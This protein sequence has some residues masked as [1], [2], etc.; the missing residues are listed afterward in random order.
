MYDTGTFS[1]RGTI[2]GMPIPSR[3]RVVAVIA[4]CVAGMLAS[5]AKDPSP[6]PES[7]TSAPTSNGSSEPGLERFYSQTLSW[8]SCRDFESGDSPLRGSVECAYLEVPVDY[9][10]PDGETAQIAMSRVETN[11]DKVGSLLFNPGGPGQPGLWMPGNFARSPLAESFDLVGFD[12]RGVGASTPEVRCLTDAETDAERLDLDIDMSPEGIAQTEKEEK[13]FIDKCVDRVG[14]DVLEH[15]GTREVVRDMDVMR[16]VL[17][18]EKL[19]Y[20]GF[21]YGTRIGAAY[22]EEFP[23]KVRALVLDGAVDASQDPNEELVEQYE[24]FQKAF[25]EF[26]ADCATKSDCPLGTDPRQAVPAFRALVEPLV[27]TPAPAGGDRVLSYGDA[28]T[29]VVQALYS[30]QFWPDL[31]AGLQ[32]LKQGKG[33][34]LLALA[35]LYEGRAED[36][37]YQNTNDSF[38]AI[39]CVDDPRITDRAVAGQTEAKVR[40]VAPFLDDG[41]GTGQAPLDD[42]AFWPVPNSSMPHEIS[43]DGLP[44]IVVVSTTQDPATPYQAGVDLARQLDGSLITFDGTQHTVALTGESDCV[45]DAVIAYLKDLT[46]PAEGLRC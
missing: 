36:G 41:R 40:E 32:E 3:T 11:G 13:D 29:G 30:P 37:T 5:C 39:R 22:A 15:T 21:S 25:D 17:G 20:V 8:G 26:A 24:G 7:T 4:F 35:D 46:V 34:T 14:K 1:V 38:L 6:K 12:P 42:C 31:E 43:V 2:L 10:E 18:D 28:H 9:D 23:D 27:T 19:S 45:D 16:A 44:K 33:D